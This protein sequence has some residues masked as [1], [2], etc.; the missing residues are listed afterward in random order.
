MK[1]PK[2][3]IRKDAIH[4]LSLKEILKPENIYV[5][6]PKIGWNSFFQK[7]YDCGYILVEINE[8]EKPIQVYQKKKFQGKEIKIQTLLH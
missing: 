3:T 6:I 1:R 4:I 8:N 7:M 2:L 5:R